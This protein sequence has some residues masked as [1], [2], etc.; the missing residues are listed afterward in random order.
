[1]NIARISRSAGKK[2]VLASNL[3][4]NTLL[5]PN[6]CVKQ[7]GQTMSKTSKYEYVK[8]FEIE[9]KLLPNCW[10]VVRID[11]KAFH[12]FSDTHKFNKPNDVNAL[13]LMNACAEHVMKEFTD[14]VISYGQSDEYSFVFRR[15]TDLYGRRSAKIATNVV[16][17]FA[18][19]Y[20]FKWRQFFPTTELKYPPSFDARAV[21]YPTNDNLRD[22]L[23]WRQVDCH[24]NNLYNT[25]FWAL[26]QKGKLSN[27]EAQLRLKGTVSGDKNE[28]LFSEFDINYN[29]EPEQFRKG[30]TIIKKKIEIPIEDLRSAETDNENHDLVTNEIVKKEEHSSAEKR[31]KCRQNDEIQTKVRSK[32]VHYSCDIIGDEFWTENAN[33][34]M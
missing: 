33:I 22:Y 31:K 5:K 24:I 34:I 7:P 16:S 12:R 11:G 2:I 26:V 32:L 9:D 28:I 20:V 25:V 15:Q 3:H 10:M 30:T 27:N 4:L 29:N 8:K 6:F 23:S 21:L 14:V 1:M 19:T 13:N 17:L 18:S